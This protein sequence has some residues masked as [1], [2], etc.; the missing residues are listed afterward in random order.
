MIGGLTAL[1]TAK[2]LLG[3]GVRRRYWALLVAILFAMVVCAIVG[4]TI[5]RIAYRPLRNARGWPR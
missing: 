5:E 1:V 4:V 2:W 3:M